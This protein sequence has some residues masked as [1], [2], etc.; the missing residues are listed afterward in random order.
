VAS[1]ALA[2]AYRGKINDGLHNVLKEG[3]DKY[4]NDTETQKLIDMIQTEVSL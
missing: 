2:F 1:I 3:L 4:D